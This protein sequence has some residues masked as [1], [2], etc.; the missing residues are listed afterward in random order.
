MMKPMQE[1]DVTDSTNAVHVKNEINLSWPIEP[2]TV[3]DENQTG[4][5][6]DRSYSSFL[7]LNQN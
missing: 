1:N 4:Y 2:G 3:C 7:L 5:R 6:H